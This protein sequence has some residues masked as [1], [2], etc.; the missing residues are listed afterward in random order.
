MSNI[1][2]SKIFK[3]TFFL[4]L[5]AEVLSFWGWKF[6]IVNSVCFWALAVLVLILSLKKLEYGLYFILAELFVGSF[7]YIFSFNFGE[8]RISLRMILFLVVMAVF[9]MSVILRRSPPASGDDEESRKNKNTETTTPSDIRRRP[10]LRKEGMTTAALFTIIL[11]FSFLHGLF[12]GNGFGN[13]FL[14]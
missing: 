10:L 5:L 8:T 14:D 13:I 4:L 6:P 3:I 9:L 7:G 12:R 1:L 11:L 2:N